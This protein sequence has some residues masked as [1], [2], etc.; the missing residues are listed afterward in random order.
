MDWLSNGCVTTSYLLAATGGFVN[1]SCTHLTDFAGSVSDAPSP[2][3]SPASPSI[4]LIVGGVVGAIVVVGI[5]V[6]IV[7]TMNRGR[8]AAKGKLLRPN[9]NERANEQ[10]MKMNPASAVGSQV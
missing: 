2:A 6:A 1:C 4:A 7:V 8:T 3:A 9:A 10:I 5:L